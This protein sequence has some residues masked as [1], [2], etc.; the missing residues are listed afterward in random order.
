M[1]KKILII[2]VLFLVSFA[3]AGEIIVANT[4]DT[5]VEKNVIKQMYLGKVKKWDDGTHVILTTLKK[6]QTH[7]NFLSTYVNKQPMQFSNYW[8][9]LVFTGRGK[10]PK[11]FDNE[12]DLLK[13]ISSNKGAIGY[14]SDKNAGLLPE[15]IK[16][17]KIE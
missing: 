4:S 6:G 3:F 9:Q 5:V 10:M 2:G 14:V 8:K 17:I 16:A 1:H 11:S 12:N 13:F 15:N 7:D